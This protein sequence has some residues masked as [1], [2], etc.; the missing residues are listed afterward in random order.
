MINICCVMLMK[1]ILNWE[2]LSIAQKRA[3]AVIYNI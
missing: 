3:D 2:A 1:S